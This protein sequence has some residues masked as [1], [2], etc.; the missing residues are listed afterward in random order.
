MTQYDR[1]EFIYTRVFNNNKIP[2]EIPID[3]SIGTI[4]E[5]NITCKKFNS[6]EAILNFA[7]IYIVYDTLICSNVHPFVE[8]DQ[9][10]KLLSTHVIHD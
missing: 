8:I 3:F 4:E 10:T 5:W 1:D 9:I 6:G 2:S 7:L